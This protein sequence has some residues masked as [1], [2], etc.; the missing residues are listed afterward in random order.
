MIVGHLLLVIDI[1]DSR[2]LERSQSI[3]VSSIINYMPNDWSLAIVGAT[4]HVLSILMTVPMRTP[5]TYVKDLSIE[6]HTELA[7]QKLS[8][9]QLQ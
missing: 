9:L 6:R 2:S 3:L 1:G 7:F 8:L 4:S 5:K